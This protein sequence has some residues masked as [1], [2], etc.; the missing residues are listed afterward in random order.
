MQESERR[1]GLTIEALSS[2]WRGAS[3]SRRLWMT[4]CTGRCSSVDTAQMSTTAGP[5]ARLSVCFS[6]SLVSVRRRAD[7][8][9]PPRRWARRSSRSECRTSTASRSRGYRNLQGP[10]PPP[11]LETGQQKHT[12]PY[13]CFFL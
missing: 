6:S 3:A 5:P 4:G 8:P 9:T 7:S 12:E 13:L 2:P 10:N 11:D 1:V